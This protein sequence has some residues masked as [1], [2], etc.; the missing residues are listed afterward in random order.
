MLTEVV[1]EGSNESLDEVSA[2]TQARLQAEEAVAQAVQQAS[3]A[4][5]RA[6]AAWQRAAHAASLAA[7]AAQQFASRSS[8]HADAPDAGDAE[9]LVRETK[10]EALLTSREAQVEAAKASALRSRKGLS[11]A[12]IALAAV[13]ILAIAI[14]WRAK[15]G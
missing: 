14:A 7:Y 12:S 13:G 4:Q 11:L 8:T 3:A 15:R 10:A 2:R 5:E 1:R 9:R 6:R